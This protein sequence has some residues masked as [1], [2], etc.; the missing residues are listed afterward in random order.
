MT[1]TLLGEKPQATPGNSADVYDLGHV[2]VQ[3]L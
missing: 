3:H 1:A 2:V